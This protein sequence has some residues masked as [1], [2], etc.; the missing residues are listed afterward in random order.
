MCISSIDW[1]FLWQGHQEIM[2]RF[3][4]AGSRVIFVE[5]TGV[6]SIGLRDLRR[7]AER[8]ARWLGAEVGQRPEPRPGVRV[9]APMLVPLTRSPLAR[10]VNDRI[11]LPRLARQITA[12]GATDPIIFACL[13]TR[14][15][16]GLIRLLKTPSSRVVYYCVGDFLALTDAPRELAEAERR[17]V[18]E[19]DAVFVQGAALRERF[20]EIGGRLHDFHVGVNLEVF[21]PDREHAVAEELVGLPRPIIG[22]SGGLHQYVDF[23]LIRAVARAL[24]DASV[25]LVGPAQT[26]VRML[27]VEPNVHLLGRRPFSELPAYVAGFDVALIP[28]VRSSYTQTVFPTKLFE[29]L[30]LGVPVVGTDLPELVRLG[31]PPEAL[32][33]AASER[34]FVASVHE[35]SRAPS[36][37]LREMRRDLARSHGWD[38]IVR[39][40]TS[41]I[42]DAGDPA[43]FRS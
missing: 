26:N 4:A 19:A 28:Y 15:A 6:R 20:E 23:A 11:L 38:A 34:G 41:V 37:G 7:V 10:W 18:S 40:M 36:D 39:R 21:D 1:G 33:L 2:S 32:R 16:L 3:A 29:Y 35:L 8:A 27:G 9:V 12:L 42:L 13:P 14:N 22:Y 25:V 17:L 24:P 43:P 31:L 5:N 30:A